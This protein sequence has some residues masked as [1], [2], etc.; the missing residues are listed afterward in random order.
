MKRVL[1]CA[2]AV[3]LASSTAWAAI[4][5][6]THTPGPG[7]YATITAALADAQSGDTI[8]IIDNS[9]PFVE[10]VVVDG[11]VVAKNN[12][13]IRGAPALAPRP[14][15]RGTGAANPFDPGMVAT[16]NYNNQVDGLR[17]ENLV[18]DSSGL[19]G[20]AVDARFWNGAHFLNCRIVAGSDNAIRSQTATIF[21]GCE[22]IGGSAG[23]VQF[24]GGPLV[25]RDSEARDAID[26]G[27]SVLGGSVRIEGSTLDSQAGATVILQDVLAAVDFSMERTILTCT[28][29]FA[30]NLLVVFAGGSG[31]GVGV[32]IANSDLIGAGGDTATPFT[33]AGLIAAGPV[34]SLSVR[35]SIFYNIFSVAYALL[36]N[37]A[38]L[39]DGFED[40]NVYRAAPNNLGD[41]GVRP[42][43]NNFGGEALYVDPDNGDFRLVDNSSAATRSSPDGLGLGYVGSQGLSGTTDPFA[44]ERN[45]TPI[46]SGFLN[47]Y[48]PE[49]V[50][51]LAYPDFPYRMYFFGWATAT[52]N[53]GFPGSDAIFLARASDLAGPWQVYAG[54]GAWDASGNPSSW[55]PVITAGDAFY[56]E[57]HNGDPSIQLVGGVYYMALSTTGF[58]LDRIPDGQ[59]GDT[60]G[61]ISV[62]MMATSSDGITW[63]KSAAPVLIHEPEI[64]QLEF[65]LPDYQG[66]FHRP[67]LRYDEDENRWRMWFDFWS[68]TPNGLSM[69]YAQT[70]PGADPMD[71]ASWT[72]QHS[73]DT[74]PLPQFPNPDVVKIDGAYHA[75]GDPI[76]WLNLPGFAGRQLREAASADPAAGWTLRPY[77]I[78]PDP[79]RP[80]NQVP[81]ARLF[82]VGPDQYLYLFYSNQ[83]GGFPSFDSNNNAINFM[84]RYVGPASGASVGMWEVFDY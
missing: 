45:E 1:F 13:I 50:L 36:G 66:N 62:V 18:I 81:Q 20:T 32:D 6:V 25:I 54:S 3:L 65:A 4:L 82:D 26:V 10:Q 19:P 31:G 69:G 76:G 37:T 34:T 74:P 27:V 17:F 79:G 77:H 14:T 41:Q 53:P 61:D 24:F 64:G 30:N 80:T 28:A 57:W 15:I 40:W 5:E 2:G 60:D 59:A 56:D 23:I 67:S 70:A 49:I 73:L 33:G 75:F 29:P 55:R 83:V 7:Q 35:D 68:S 38:G 51:D 21:E 46:L 44:F 16:V 58:D 72:I 78:D 22:I 39:E 71:P 9:A 11:S 47:M 12:L 52:S 63:T 48:Q 42:G 84:R 43:P 8:E